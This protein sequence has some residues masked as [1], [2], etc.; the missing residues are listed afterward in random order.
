MPLVPRLARACT[1]LRYRSDRRTLTAASLALKVSLKRDWSYCCSCSSSVFEG[2]ST[3]VSTCHFLARK[4]AIET[5]SRRPQVI[6]SLLHDIFDW[7]VHASVLDSSSLILLEVSPVQTLI[8]VSFESD[9]SSWYPLC[10][11][12][13]L[14]RQQSNSANHLRNEERGVSKGRADEK[15]CRIDRRVIIII[16]YVDDDDPILFSS[17]LFIFSLTWSI[18][19]TTCSSSSRSS[20]TQI[21]RI[22]FTRCSSLFSH[23]HRLLEVPSSSSV[24]LA[25]ESSRRLPLMR[26]LCVRNYWLPAL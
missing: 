7:T 20:D 4:A 17:G 25:W 24:F 23:L 21:L 16:E 1:K 15:R 10:L 26:L 8:E 12:F 14:F 19:A 6:T 3:R 9:R 2:I 18:F 11:S 13:S 5:S 22:I